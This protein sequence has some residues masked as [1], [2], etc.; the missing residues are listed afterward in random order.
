M[1]AAHKAFKQLVS[2]GTITG[3]L[4][5]ITSGL[6]VDDLV[7]TSGFAQLTNGLTVSVNQVQ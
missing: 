2:V 5:E 4:V 3:N 6:A 7:I 1:P